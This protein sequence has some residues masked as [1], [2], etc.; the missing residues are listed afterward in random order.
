MSENDDV[1]LSPAYQ[2]IKD[3]LR[4]E[5]DDIR[6][7]LERLREGLKK[8]REDYLD[9]ISRRASVAAEAK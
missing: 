3:M 6:A 2:V 5:M 4:D 1:P 8:D 7:S 9:M